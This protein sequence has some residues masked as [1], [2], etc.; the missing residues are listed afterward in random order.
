MK[1]CPE[2]GQELTLRIIDDIKRQTCHDNNCGFVYWNNP[3]PVVAA[4]V[5][6]NGQYIIARNAAWPK[7]IYSLITGY[8]EQ[9]ETPEEAV[10]REVH[11]ELGLKGKIK[12][13]IGHYSFNEKNQLIICYEIQAIGTIK[14]NHELS[15]FKQLSK[16]QLVEYDFSPLYVTEKI[17]QDWIQHNTTIA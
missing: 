17:I 6:Y 1:Y 13:F 5:E 14:L 9:N 16:D 12:Q 2:C 11:E 10:L 15:D 8:L 3:V 7:G 4:L